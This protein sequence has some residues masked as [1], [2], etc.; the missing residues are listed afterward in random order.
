MTP[1]QQ[2]ALET[3]AGRALAPGEIVAIDALLPD[4]N[5]V[6][7]ASILSAGRVTTQPTPIGI[8]TVL[9]VMAPS[10]GDFLNALEQLG[11]ADA[12][13]KWSLK[14]I[15]QASFDVGHPVTRAQLQAFSAAQP[16]MAGAI[17]ALLAVAEQPDPIHYNTVSDALN[18][19]EGRLTLQGG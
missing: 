2:T 18:V 1:A 15:E 6:Q 4:R 14:M 13:V 10:G 9:A 19:A 12:N 5:D 3:V 7:I 8:G 17:A 16:S 11:A